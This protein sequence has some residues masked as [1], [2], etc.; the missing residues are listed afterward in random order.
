MKDLYQKMEEVELMFQGARNSLMAWPNCHRP[1]YFTTD[2]R[3]CL[4]YTEYLTVY[5]LASFPS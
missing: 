4:H 3:H 5:V 2:L 1:P